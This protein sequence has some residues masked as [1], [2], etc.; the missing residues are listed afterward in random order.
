MEQKGKSDLA[1]RLYYEGSKQSSGDHHCLIGA[2]LSIS[3]WYVDYTAEHYFRERYERLLRKD[4]IV[5]FNKEVFDLPEKIV[6]RQTSDRVRAAIIGPHWFANTLQ[7]GVL[8]NHDYDLR[9][10]LGLLNSTFLN[11]IYVE[12]VKEA[13]RVFPQ[14]KLAKVRSLPFRRVDFSDPADKRLHDRMVTLVDS[15]I[16]FNKQRAAAKSV[17][18][19]AIVQRQIDAMDAEINRLVYDLYG[20]TA[21]E[22]ALVERARG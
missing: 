4:E 2:D 10:I 18:Q 22:I 14:V 16:A 19:G 17:A 13:G 15:M 7:A 11:F 1:S 21:E 8:L 12:T 20:L 6:W 5:Y 9:Y 3:C